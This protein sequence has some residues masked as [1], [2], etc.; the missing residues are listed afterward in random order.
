MTE[1]TKKVAYGGGRAPS[2]PSPAQRARRANH[3]GGLG[4]AE[5]DKPLISVFSR[6]CLSLQLLLQQVKINKTAA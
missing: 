3:P 6:I 5:G 2:A 1:F 4:C